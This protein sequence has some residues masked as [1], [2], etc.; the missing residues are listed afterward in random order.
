MVPEGSLVGTKAAPF[1][2]E[3]KQLPALGHRI[4][5]VDASRVEFLTKNAVQT[6]R[7][8][9]FNLRDLGGG[10]LVLSPNEMVRGLFKLH[11]PEG[12][13]PIFES[14]T[15]LRGL[16][17]SIGDAAPGA[18]EPGER[19]QP[20]TSFLGRLLLASR[21]KAQEGTEVSAGEKRFRVQYDRLTGVF[22]IEDL[23]PLNLIARSLAKRSSAGGGDAPAEVPPPAG[24]GARAAQAETLPAEA[25]VPAEVE[26]E[27]APPL[28]L[29]DDLGLDLDPE[30]LAEAMRSN[31]SLSDQAIQSAMASETGY[32]AAHEVLDDDEDPVGFDEVGIRAAL[33]HLESDGVF[34]PAPE[35]AAEPESAPEPEPEDAAEPEEAV[36]PE[37][38]PELRTPTPGLRLVELAGTSPGMAAV[39]DESDPRGEGFGPPGPS[40]MML[41]ED[42]AEAPETFEAL[43][44]GR[45][46]VE[47]EDPLLDVRRRHLGV[48]ARWRA[49]RALGR[50]GDLAA[51]PILEELLEDPEPSIRTMAAVSLRR[52]RAESH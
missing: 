28:D 29:E 5:V 41:V 49:V 7:M 31:T 43:D 48:T 36:E 47:G 15:E 23:N 37:P 14:E 26:P 45:P 33:G 21:S 24:P 42:P 50:L 12:L 46:A 38:E 25:M 1:V 39:L 9:A 11:D 20:S 22:R 51:I 17:D 27:A 13:I 3:L 40:G 2:D 16:L 18:A 10:L 32:R 4:V 30:L 34:A 35:G 44:Q 52:L 6:M 19:T 8:T